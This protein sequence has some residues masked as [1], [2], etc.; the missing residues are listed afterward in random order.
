MICRYFSRGWL[1]ALVLPALWAASQGAFAA[2]PRTVYNPVTGRTEANVRT[3]AAR[4]TKTTLPATQGQVKPAQYGEEIATP[5]AIE[6]PHFS[7]GMGHSGV[8][9]YGMGYAG[10]SIGGV[11]G[12]CGDSCG[13]CC[14]AVGCGGCSP[15]ASF[16]A[17]FEAVFVKPRYE[18]NVAFTEM[19]SDGSSTE[20]Y[21]QREFDYDL[22]FSPRVFV[23]WR[24]CDGI[25]FRASW[26]Q[27][28][29]A[30]APM[31]ANP[32][33]N[34]FGRITHPEFDGI[35]ISSNVPG[36]TFAASTSLNAY[37]VDFE[38]TKD[39]E[40]C[41][42]NFGVG[43]GVRYAYVEQGYLATLRDSGNDALGAIDY[44]HTLEG[45][46]PTISA[47]A[48]R[49]INCQTGL[50]CKARGSLLFGDGES[51]LTAGEDLD[52]TTP[53]TT[54]RTTSRDDLLTIA[55]I[56]LGLQYHSN[57]YNVYQPFFSVALEG[58][59]WNGAGTAT[60]EEGTLGFFGFNTGAGLKW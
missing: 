30:A 39:T 57:Y 11:D 47:H 8:G 36:D 10:P 35:D 21:T 37:A 56:Q 27:F 44:R 15:A 45:F 13:S 6:D 31:E 25:G 2:D 33:A 4:T 3:P 1:A 22:E 24:H 28:D 26:W 34:G 41:S 60:S 12:C 42:W 5:Y 50:F 20:S 19:T 59:V 38:F 53:F 52:L 7:H 58:Q 32:P 49:P 48:F 43:G 16:Y 14:D 46:G 29:H 51:N 18:S 17:G 54:T 40:F 23:G 9:H 55:E